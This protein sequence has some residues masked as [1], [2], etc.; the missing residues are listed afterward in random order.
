ML[1]SYSTVNSNISTQL[2]PSL[3][4]FNNDLGQYGGAA[5]CLITSQLQGPRFEFML[6]SGVSHVPPISQKIA[7][8]LISD[9]K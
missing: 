2:S 1:N 3:T 4:N 5:G 9:C 7:S 8:R 6:L